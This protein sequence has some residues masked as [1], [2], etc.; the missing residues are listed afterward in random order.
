MHA[1]ASALV[2]SAALGASQPIQV[3]SKSVLIP[4]VQD[5]YWGGEVP[6]TSTDLGKRQDL[7]CALGETK[8]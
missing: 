6:V 7:P 4:Q 2:V 5:L 3:I 1:L 8:P